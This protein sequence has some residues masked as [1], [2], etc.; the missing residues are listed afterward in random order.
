MTVFRVAAADAGD[1]ANGRLAW[2]VLKGTACHQQSLPHEIDLSHCVMLRP[3]ALACLTA[4]AAISRHRGTRIRLTWP[5]DRKCVAHCM[6]LKL[7]EWFDAPELPTPVSRRTN[8]AIDQLQQLP[9]GAFSNAIVGLLANERSLPTGI[10]PN[11]EN[12]LDEVV[13]NAVTH[14]DSEIG[15]IVV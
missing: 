2:D 7:H 6:R 14:S 1:F 13:A 4:L 10:L 3:Y 8:V 12:H 5:R 9:D 15:C 11:L